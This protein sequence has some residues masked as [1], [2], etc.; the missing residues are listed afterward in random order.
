MINCK[1]CNNASQKIFSK[2]ILKK[3][4]A[5]FF[6]C[7]NCDFV[8]TSEPIWIEEAYSSAITKLDIGILGRNVKLSIEVPPIIDACFPLAKKMLDYAGGYG[9]FARLMRD[10]GFDFYRQ[11]PYCENIFA[12]YFDITDANITKFDIVTAFEVFEHFVNPLEEIAR[13]F[14]YSDN[15]IFST[16]LTPSGNKEIENWWYISADTGQHVAFY[17]EKSLRIIAEKFGKKYYCKNGNLHVFTS[18]DFTADQFDYGF[19]DI[20][21]RTRLKG[22]IK[23]KLDFYIKRPSFR[24][25]DYEKVK[26][27]INV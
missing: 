9:V 20:R 17:S 3:Y 10:L 2:V 27:I 21:V 5:D 6:R 8:Q 11:D 4:A 18:G 24:E 12:K 15:V 22:L 26:Q 19:R 7:T 13:I 1:I 25:Q 14:S 16:E 23:Q